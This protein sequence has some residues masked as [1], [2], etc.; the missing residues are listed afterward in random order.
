[1]ALGLTW[2]APSYSRSYTTWVSETG[3]QILCKYMK[4]RMSNINY[5]NPDLLQEGIISSIMVNNLGKC[6]LKCDL[7]SGNL[8]NNLRKCSL[9][10]DLNSGNSE[11]PVCVMVQ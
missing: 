9:K 4:Y 11:V 7:N 6:R 10:C 1:M 3:H 5:V 8:V 2:R